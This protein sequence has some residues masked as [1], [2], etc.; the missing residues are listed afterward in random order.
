M[1]LVSPIAGSRRIEHVMGTTFTF[2]VRDPRFHEASL[3]GA[4][5]WLHW[6][7]HTFST[8]D[9]RSELR[10][11]AAG[12]LELDECSDELVEVI[13]LCVA[14]EAETEG[15]FSP[16]YRGA[17]DPAGL[18]RAGRSSA[19]ARCSCRPAHAPT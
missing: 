7:E 1:S 13:D 6:V 18:V 19:P 16:L 9:P 4:V 10:R 5:A 2:D 12:T 3:D 17:L 14:V 11:L 15:Y 8:D